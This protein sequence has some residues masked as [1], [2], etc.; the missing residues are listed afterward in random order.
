LTNRTYTLETNPIGILGVSFRHTRQQIIESSE[1]IASIKSEAECL[2]ARSVLTNPKDRI[3]AELSWLPG[4]SPRRSWELLAKIK[5]DI[6]SAFN[7]QNIPQLVKINLICNAIE[8]GIFLKSQDSILKFLDPLTSLI[9]SFNILRL[10]SEIN[11]DRIIAKIPLINDIEILRDA[12]SERISGVAATVISAL[13]EMQTDHMLAAVN[14]YSETWTSSGSNIQSTFAEAILN[15]YE[16]Q[17]HNFLTTEAADIN[18]FVDVIIKKDLNSNDEFSPHVQNL[19]FS[20]KN[21]VN[22]A[23][24]VQFQSEAS[25]L[26]HA[27]SRTVA[28]A[29]IDLAF[30]LSF[31]LRLNDEGLE[32]ANFCLNEF[33][34]LTDLRDSINVDINRLKENKQKHEISYKARFGLIFKTYLEVRDQCVI[35]KNH[36]LRF[37]DITK[38]RWAS[39][40][41][42]ISIKSYRIAWGDG[43]DE[44][45]LLTFKESIFI[46]FR[47]ILL[48]Q[49]GYNLVANKITQ[50]LNEGKIYVFPSISILDDHVLL[51]K[52]GIF[53]GKKSRPFAWNEVFLSKSNGGIRI[54][55]KGDADFYADIKYLDFWNVNLLGMLIEANLAKVGIEKLSLTYKD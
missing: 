25:G 28:G 54:G 52:R 43:E 21:W 12:L 51:Q 1:D 44:D 7:D 29:L 37:K 14:K 35:F 45:L 55:A 18:K 5:I 13:G 39:S 6:Y 15:R 9:D 47:D 22:V 24:P 40:P 16:A 4:V 33:W 27:L 50:E 30:H 11:E 32:L 10:Q 8:H 53:S 2:R 41:D 38:L 42:D 36:S 34:I 19:K 20:V 17:T 26:K 46:E 3:Y 23:R 31:Q 49:I 48:N